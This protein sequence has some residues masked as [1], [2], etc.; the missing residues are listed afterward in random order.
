ME[1]K[2]CMFVDTE[3]NIV[4]APKFSVWLK[5]VRSPSIKKKY[6]LWKAFNTLESFHIY[7]SFSIAP[8]LKLYDELVKWTTRDSTEFSSTWP[9]V[10]ITSFEITGCIDLVALGWIRRH[11]DNC[12]RQDTSLGNFTWQALSGLLTRFATRD[13]MPIGLGEKEHGVLHES[14]H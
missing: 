13:T 8:R 4:H 1:G 5:Y 2:Y 9:I 14:A 3:L 10:S 11:S 6:E 7:E 12:S